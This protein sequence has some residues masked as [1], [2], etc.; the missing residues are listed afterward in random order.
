MAG[1]AGRAAIVLGYEVVPAVL[2]GV[3]EVLDAV[4]VGGRVVEDDEEVPEA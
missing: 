1:R 2:A 4:R 3:V